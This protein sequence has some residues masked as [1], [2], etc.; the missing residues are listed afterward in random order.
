MLHRREF[1]GSALAIGT[2]SRTKHAYGAETPLRFAVI[3]DVQYADKDAAGKRDYRGA[4]HRLEEAADALAGEEIAFSIQLGDLIDGGAAN[5]GPVLDAYQRMPAPRYHV[6]G[7]HDFFGPRRVV[8]K[9]FG[10][11]RAHYTFQIRGWKFISIDGMNLSVTGGWQK[12]SRNYQRAAQILDELKAS[13]AINA[14][15]W[16]GAVGREQREWLRRE[17]ASARKQGERCVVFCH[18][19]TLAEACRP[20]HLLLDHAEVLEVLDSQP[21]TVAYVNGHDHSGGYAEHAGVHHVT[22]AGLVESDVGKCLRVFDLNPD[23][24]VVRKPG[25]RE[26]QVLPIPDRTA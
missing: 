9:R 11:K 10:L 6:L 20:A 3:S 12:E 22:L 23:H 17:L 5:V 4:L 15:D 24:I 25:Q 26:G 16:N 7:N 14:Y 8:L 19:P 1:I 13:G 2:A 21:S 18:F